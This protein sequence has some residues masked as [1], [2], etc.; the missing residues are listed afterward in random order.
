MTR[1]GLS[2]SERVVQ[3]KRPRQESV[4]AV[5]MTAQAAKK[6]SLQNLKKVSQK[7]ARK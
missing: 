4:T 3:M 6:T 2:V 1:R 7:V 5:T